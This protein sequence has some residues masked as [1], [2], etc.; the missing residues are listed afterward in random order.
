MLKREQIEE[1][2]SYDLKFLDDKWDAALLGYAQSGGP[3]R[4]ILPCYGY[5]ALKAIIRSSGISDGTDTYIA[6][7]LLYNSMPIEAPLVLTKLTR[8]V[9][10][11][12]AKSK[13]FMRW[14]S[15][16]NAVLGI[17]KLKYTTTGLVY[18]KPLCVDIL[19]KTSKAKGNNTVNA[20][21]KLEEELIPVAAQR[22][23][24]WYLTPVK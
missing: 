12:E 18:S 19:A 16:D 7:Q 5:Q 23:T 9:L 8:P 6:M 20:I 11:N 13:N 2:V 1:E 21:H 17:G 14:E 24:P 3:G 10:W 22:Y 15:L 4:H